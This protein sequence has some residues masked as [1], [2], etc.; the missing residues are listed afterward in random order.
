MAEALK[1]ANSIFNNRDPER[2]RLKRERAQKEFFNDP[3]IDAA[4]AI[5][6]FDTYGGGSAERPMLVVRWANMLPDSDAAGCAFW[7]AVQEMWTSFDRIPH[8]DYARLF[9]RFAEQWQPGPEIAGLPERMTA[10]R[11]QSADAPIGLSWTLDR[12]VAAGFARGHRFITVPNPAIFKVLIPRNLVVLAF[13]DDR[14]EAE[15]V[16]KSTKGLDTVEC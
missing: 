15:I 5:T 11:G 14:K 9:H 10:Y 6:F 8:D 16:V 3:P 2:G 7:T 12:D 13:P 4:T 1:P